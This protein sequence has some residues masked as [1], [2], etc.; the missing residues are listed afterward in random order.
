MQENGIDVRNSIINDD[1]VP[2][3][4]PV[5]EFEKEV[6][7]PEKDSECQKMW[8]LPPQNGRR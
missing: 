2:N 4:L 5:F 3:I 1:T 6:K 8:V 7:C